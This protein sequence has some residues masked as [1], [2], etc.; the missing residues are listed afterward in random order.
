VTEP[1]SDDALVDIANALAG[2][3]R[4]LAGEGVT[5][6]TTVDV[7]PAQPFGPWQA[8]V[9]TV[10]AG[11]ATLDAARAGTLLERS[12]AVTDELAAVLP[13]AAAAAAPVGR[14]PAV[15]AAVAAAVEDAGR[16]TALAGEDDAGFLLAVEAAYASVL[17]AAYATWVT[18]D[19]LDPTVATTGSGLVD[20][21]LRPRAA[22]GRLRRADGA[23]V[24]LDVAA[25]QPAATW[26]ALAG[27][28]AGRGDEEAVTAVRLRA[29]AAVRGLGGAEE[30]IVAGLAPADVE[31]E[32]ALAAAVA[33][34]DAAVAAAA[35]DADLADEATCRRA[36]RTWDALP[37]A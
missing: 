7:D 6:S 31:P 27:A 19:Q 24:V 33:V 3:R 12:P 13:A 9:T 16:L 37:R 2:L 1:V 8:V 18:A 29:L 25:A 21:V 11:V 20:V 23:T 14:G 36:S 28:V 4:E 10:R 5:V 15:D 32:V 22:L 35:R 34:G 17:A 26:E 30:R